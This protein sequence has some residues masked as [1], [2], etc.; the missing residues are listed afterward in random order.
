MAFVYILRTRGTK[1]FKVGRTRGDVEQ[2]IRALITGN[3]YL[4]RFDVIETPDDALFEK[5]L[6]I[7]LDPYKIRGSTAQEFFEI[8]EEQLKI[9]IRE[10]KDY[11][12]EYGTLIMEADRYKLVNE[13]RGERLQ[14]DN[15]IIKIY[16]RLCQLRYDINKLELEENLLKCKL[17]IRIADFDGIEGVAD[18]L[19]TK[20]T[21]LDQMFL[22]NEEPEIF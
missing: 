8:E 22:R 21:I 14:A 5:I 7:K 2:R 13:T 12:D 18:W 1:E 9:I 4:E 19:I 16:E 6:H 3:P 10:A 11:I 17:Q 20:R 15:D